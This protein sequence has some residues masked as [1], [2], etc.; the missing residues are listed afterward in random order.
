MSKAQLIGSACVRIVSGLVVLKTTSTRV[1]MCFRLS[2]SPVGVHLLVQEG[3]APGDLSIHEF[4]KAAGR[5]WAV[6][7]LDLA[8]IKNLKEIVPT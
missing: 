5:I 4:V 6:Q 7:E 3:Q 2:P 1:R 8:A